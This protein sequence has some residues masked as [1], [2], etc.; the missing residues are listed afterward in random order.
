MSAWR[1]QLTG[2]LELNLDGTIVSDA[3][4]KHLSPLKALR[5]LSLSQT[6]VQGD[7]FDCLKDAEGL[8]EIAPM[9]LPY[10]G[11]PPA[12]NSLSLRPVDPHLHELNLKEV[13]R[14][15]QLKLPLVL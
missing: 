10:R 7:G 14:V 6:S 2:L 8:T 12:S 3:G 1:G 5:K 15:L 4:L 13:I 9:P 11:G